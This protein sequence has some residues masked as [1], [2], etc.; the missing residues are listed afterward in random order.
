MIQVRK[1]INLSLAKIGSFQF[2]ESPDTATSDIC[3]DNLKLML[4]EL[5]IRFA[6]WKRYYETVSSKN[7]ITLG[8]DA[9]DP[10]NP[11]IGDISARPAQI[12]D[13]VVQIGQINFPQ[14]IKPF[15]EY[16]ELR[17]QNVAAIPTTVYIDYGSPFITM[18]FYPLF[19]TQGTIK[20]IGRGYTT[21]ED[22]YLNDYLDFPRE[23]QSAL[24]SNLALR[25]APS[26]GVTA[27]TSLVI[28]ASSDLKH[29]KQRQLIEQ[30]RTI[31]SDFVG[32]KGFNLIAGM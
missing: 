18:Y 2:G 16:N 22:L 20:V 14:S 21:D 10:L 8:T 6:N 23:W 7:I 27:D 1:I 9:T 19:G 25:I 5:D 4:D 17:V 31:N 28:Q 29:I 13:V 15:S 24:V 3:V 32:N 12:T 26:F 11:I 30:M